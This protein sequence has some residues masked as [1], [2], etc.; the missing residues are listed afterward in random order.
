MNFAASW[1]SHFLANTLTC[2]AS[3]NLALFPGRRRNGLA[4][5]ASSNCIQMWHHGN[6]NMHS[7]CLVHVILAIFPAGRMGL[8]CSWKQLFAVGSTSEVK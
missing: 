8:S 1:A 2:R 3:S 5:S 6:C 4:T 7:N